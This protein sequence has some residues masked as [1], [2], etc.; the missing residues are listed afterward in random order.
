MLR[1]TLPALLL[2]VLLAL[3]ALAQ[4]DDRESRR[5]EAMQRWQHLDQS[6]QERGL[7]R[8]EAHGLFARFHYAGGNGTAYGRFVRFQVQPATASL[9]DVRVRAA[10]TVA[11]T[12][13]FASV[14]PS[15]FTLQDGP[16]VHGATLVMAGSSLDFMAHNNPLSAMSWRA[17]VPVDVTFTLAQSLQATRGDAHEARVVVGNTH[18]HIATNAAANLTIASDGRSVVAHLAAGDTLFLRVHPVSDPSDK[19]G[20]HQLLSAFKLRRLGGF[21]RI[22]DANGT[23]VEDGEMA[24]VHASTR[25]IARG[26]LVWDVDSAQHEGRILFLTLDNSSLDLVRLDRVEARLDD[27]RLAR[28]QTVAEVLASTSP[29][30]AFAVVA[31]ADGLTVTVAVYV[32]HFSSYALSL[33]QLAGGTSTSG[34]ASS[35]PATGSPSSGGTSAGAGSSSTKAPGP[36]GLALLLALTGLAVLLRRRRD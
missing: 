30:G 3:P 17:G 7:E 5:A 27:S 13:L 14:T 24:D 1:R 28:V 33:T 16:A 36:G 6:T 12:P 22:A 9:Q 23:A 11:L 18:A 35:Q 21:L 2:T 31:S 4:A 10:G 19:G 26:H 32:P 15:A 8:A 34:G 25:S 20:L 29:T